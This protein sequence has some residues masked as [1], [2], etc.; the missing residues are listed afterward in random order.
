MKQTFLFIFIFFVSIQHN[1]SQKLVLSD[2]SEISIITAGPGDV[3]Y[4]AFG[5]SAIRVK[6]PTL[7]LDI[8]FNYGLF[9]FNQPNFYV[10]FVKGRLLY[11]LGK[12]SFRRFITSYDY[13]Q[14]WVK[15]QVLNLSLVDRI[16]IF[17]YLNENSLPENAE[18]LYDPY[19]NNCATKLRD[20]AKE[21]LGNKIQFPSSFSD[22]NFT[23]R[24]L[25]NQE[26]PWNTWGSFGINLA[27]GNTLDKEIIA[28]NYMYLP[29]YVHKGF[30]KATITQ[31]KMTTPLVLEERQLLRYTEKQIKIQ[32]YNPFFVFSLLLLIT[33]VVTFRDQK[34]NIR[35]KWLDFTL[36][37]VTGVLGIII[38]FLWFFTDHY[39][40]PNNFNLLWAFVLNFFVAFILLKSRIPSWTSKYLLFYLFLLFGAI[41]TSFIGLQQFSNAVFPIMAMLFLR[42]FYIYRLLTFKK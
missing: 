41:I 15:D 33:I 7:N 29:D 35:S 27:L 14:R 42:T 24:Q 28:D 30:Q 38:C 32:W 8:I 11:R 26:L 12:Q 22:E 36:F 20:I 18:Y 34:R 39:T 1:F 17:E 4:E 25:M 13:Q 5:H 23:L 10:N 6:D 40:A 19:F 31:N 21:I 2:Q 9:D 37:F 3:L 16:K